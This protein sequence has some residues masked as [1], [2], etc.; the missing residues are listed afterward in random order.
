MTYHCK[1]IDYGYNYF[2]D[3]IAIRDLHAKLWAP[4][5]AGVP[6]VGILGLPFGSFGTICHLDVA[7]VERRIE[8]YKGEG[9]GFPPVRVV[10]SLVN[11]RLPV[12]HPNTKNVQTMH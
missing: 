7:P 3:L 1:V 8:Y 10:M 12:V 2:L 11:S 4:K 5:V 6:E 9:G